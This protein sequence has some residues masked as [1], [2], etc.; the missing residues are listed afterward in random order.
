MDESEQARR[1]TD[2]HSNR[3]RSWKR[4]TNG[5]RG[6]RN[7][8]RRGV[9]QLELGWYGMLNTHTCMHT[10]M[11]PT[12]GQT[13]RCWIQ[14]AGRL[15]ACLDGCLTAQASRDRDIDLLC[16]ACPIPLVLVAIRIYN[17]RI[18]CVAAVLRKPPPIFPYT[19]RGNR[20]LPP[21]TPHKQQAQ[22]HHYCTP[23]AP[24]QAQAHST[25]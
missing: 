20:I 7:S 3:L 12:D 10:R 24:L 4:R 8:R 9:L 6:R 18:R 15:P 23:N 25:R 22:H 14:L 16:F 11:Y 5:E 19:R 13:D 2:Y 17:T 21:Q 1:S